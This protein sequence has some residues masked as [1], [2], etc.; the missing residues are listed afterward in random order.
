MWQC[1]GKCWLWIRV[2]KFKKY[3]KHRFAKPGESLNEANALVNK[4]LICIHV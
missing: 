4:N 3:F 2:E 1:K